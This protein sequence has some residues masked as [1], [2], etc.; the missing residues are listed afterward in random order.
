MAD[1]AGLPRPG[2]VTAEDS[3]DRWLFGY[4]RDETAKML[5]F[6]L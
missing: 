3:M 6:F 2:A 1:N 5:Y 4:T